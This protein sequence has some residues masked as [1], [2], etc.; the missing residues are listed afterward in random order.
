MKNFYTDHYKHAIDNSYWFNSK[1]IISFRYLWQLVYTDVLFVLQ[2]WF[3][4][5]QTNQWVSESE[6]EEAGQKVTSE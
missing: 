2:L 6:R 3:S 4:V 5:N 1:Q